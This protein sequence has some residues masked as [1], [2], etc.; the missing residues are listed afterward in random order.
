MA[1]QVQVF[2]DICIGNK[3]VHTAE[4]TAYDS[5]LAFLSKNA[6][7]YGLPLIP[8]ELD[9]EQQAILKELDVSTFTFVI[10]ILMDD[11]TLELPQYAVHT[12]KSS[13]R[14]SHRDRT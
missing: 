4:Q 13:T 11:G 6:A 8:S 3:E 2:L 12:P 14:R 5:T 10:S 7:I 1:P 9:D